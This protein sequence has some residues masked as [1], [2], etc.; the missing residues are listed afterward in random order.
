MFGRC[1]AAEMAAS[2]WH[3][4]HPD[5]GMQASSSS[6]RMSASMICG[7][8]DEMETDLHPTQALVKFSSRPRQFGV[9]PCGFVSATGNLRETRV[10]LS[11]PLFSS[12][13]QPYQSH[14]F[15]TIDN[16]M[17]KPRADATTESAR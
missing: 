11:G 1:P 10:P 5:G 2:A 17:P 14:I 9:K 6:R 8:P 13:D 3:V 4:P 15:F 16:P 12:T 7:P